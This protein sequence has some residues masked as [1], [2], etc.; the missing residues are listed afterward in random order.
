METDGASTGPNPGLITSIVTTTE[1]VTPKDISSGITSFGQY[2][3]SNC[4]HFVQTEETPQS[5][6]FYHGYSSGSEATLYKSEHDQITA[7]ISMTLSVNTDATFDELSSNEITDF[8]EVIDSS[9]CNYTKLTPNFCTVSDNTC[10]MNIIRSSQSYY[11]H[12]FNYIS[13]E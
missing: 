1:L 12:G 11:V 7:T 13:T 10:L 3:S 6:D 8:N 4:S 9:A 2:C 5:G